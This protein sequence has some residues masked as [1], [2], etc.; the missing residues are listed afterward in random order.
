MSD[1]QRTKRGDQTTRPATAVT[2]LSFCAIS[3]DGKLQLPSDSDNEDVGFDTDSELQERYL[4]KSELGRGGMGRV[5]LALDN[6]LNR[7]VAI[8]VVAGATSLDDALAREA[9]LGAGL[10]HP[11]IAAS[12]VKN[13][14][15]MINDTNE[16]TCSPGPNGQPGGYPMRIHAEGVDIVLPEGI[17]MEKALEINMGGLRMEGVEELKDDGTVVITEEANQ[18]IKELYEFD[19]KE[20]R[21]ADI[22]QVGQ[23]IAAIKKKL[24]EKYSNT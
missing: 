13:I 18:L 3:A 2:S 5:F 15:A 12:A 10:N 22:E 23:E 4:L 20:I 1:E 16:F 6:R 7:L 11:A 8:K 24:V 21:F 9:R 17:D 14:M 19:L